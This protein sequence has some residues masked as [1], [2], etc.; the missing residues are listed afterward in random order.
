MTHIPPQGVD[1][2]HPPLSDVI[3]RNIQNQAGLR[4]EAASAR[5]F[6]E[7]WQT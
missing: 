4:R 1:P 6:Q 7:R 2:D 5:S 3:Q